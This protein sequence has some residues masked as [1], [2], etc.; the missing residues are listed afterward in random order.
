MKHRIFAFLI[1]F[2]YLSATAVG[3]ADVSIT[4]EYTPIRTPCD[5]TPTS[6]GCWGDY[7]I[8]TNWY[9]E[10]PYTGVIREYWLVVQNTTVAP[11]VIDAFRIE[12][13]LTD[14]ASGL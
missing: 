8:D 5:N 10:T 12:Y 14:T 4:P 7:S 11:D 13:L 1:S 6:R 2:L 9:E 3:Q